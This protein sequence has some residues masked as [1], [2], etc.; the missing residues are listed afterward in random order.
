MNHQHWAAAGSGPR[1]GRLADPSDLLDGADHSVLLYDE[2][3]PDPTVK[4]AVPK[5]ASPQATPRQRISGDVGQGARPG[6]PQRGAVGQHP[7]PD[8]LA[9]APLVRVDH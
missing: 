8:A 2:G 9:A 7:V 3:A 6:R 5:I 4:A 1:D